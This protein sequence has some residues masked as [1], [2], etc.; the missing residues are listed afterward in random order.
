M[1]YVEAPVEI[2]GNTITV[3]SLK[4]KE[5]FVPPIIKSLNLAFTP[6]QNGKAIDKIIT[7]NNFIY[8]K[9]N[10]PFDNLVPF[11]TDKDDRH[12]SLY[13]AF[14]EDISKLPI[15]L[16]FPLAAEAFSTSISEE[17]TR[18]PRLEWECWNGEKWVPLSVVDETDEMTGR[19]MVALLV[20]DNTKP[21]ACFGEKYYWIRVRLDEGQFTADPQLTG[22]FI[23]SVW[24]QN[25]VSVQKELLGSSN[26]SPSQQFS[27]S[28]KPVL[29]GQEILIREAELVTEEKEQIEKEE[30]TDAFE[31][32][33]PSEKTGNEIWVRWHEVK[34]FWYSNP[35]SRHY[36]IDRAKGTITFGDGKRGMIP[37][38]GRNNIQARIYR[39]GG[40]VRGN[41]EAKQLIKMRKAI[42]YIES[43]TNPVPSEG[44][45]DV[46]SLD[47]VRV[48]GPRS[49]RH[50]NRAVTLTDY[51]WIVQ[52]A[53]LKI[54]KVKGLDV[55]NPQKQFKPGWVT[56]MIVPHSPDAKPLP[57]V[58]LIEEVSTYL[59]RKAPSCLTEMI[60]MKQIHLIPPNYL[61][62][63]VD[64]DVVVRS[65]GDAKDTEIQ[66]LDR[67]KE[68]LHP[69]K[70]G[71]DKKGWEFGR[72]VYK[73]EIY[74]AIEGIDLVDYVHDISLKA[75]EQIYTIEPEVALY[76][77]TPFPE[78]SRVQ[79]RDN[80]IALSMAEDLAGEKECK[81]FPVIGFMEGDHIELKYVDESTEIESVLRLFVTDVD[82]PL[83]SC[84]PVI[85]ENDFPSE[86]TQVS[87]Y[88]KPEALM[89][90]SY[91][92]STIQR[93]QE[94][95]KFEV[96]VPE[97]RDRFVVT[98]REWRSTTVDGLVKNISTDIETVYLEKDYLVYSGSHEISITATDMDQNGEESEEGETEPPVCGG[99]GTDLYRY[100]I[101]TRTREVHDLA[102]LMPRCGV[103]LMKEQ[104]K[105]FLRSLDDIED[106]LKKGAFDYCAWCFGKDKSEY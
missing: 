75:S 44:G 106:A 83:L 18:P 50:R 3:W 2:G 69:L 33:D 12:P 23:N 82:G 104:H 20:P 66:V 60:P 10:A 19:G 102:N 14:D 71:P 1:E 62:V 90:S 73:T 29:S 25:K 21:A 78:Q 41:V 43:V 45:T 100:L 88:L 96:A 80:R 17:E 53:S 8:Q 6:E 36:V 84:T 31:K 63:D 11:K 74:E 77:S 39:H 26:G 64:I 30:G 99:P 32:I 94:V 35:N 70:G 28:N 40:G 7:Y 89:V 105:C 27:F 24:A 67:L 92:K 93:D 86:K 97:P 98:H 52:E 13:L 81:K 61:R 55:T 58:E 16:F 68:F 42:P 103:R 91:L 85:A 59:A 15:T 57:T 46:E 4:T 54:A 101:N 22:I 95:T 56:I 87:T 79:F 9:F 37:Q 51:E 47:Q 65:I 49:I 38:A 34:H 76:S 72:D 48:R 5:S